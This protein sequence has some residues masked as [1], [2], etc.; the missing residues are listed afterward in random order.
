MPARKCGGSTL[1]PAQQVR[2][3][4]MHKSA[5]TRRTR[6]STENPKLTSIFMSQHILDHLFQRRPIITIPNIISPCPNLPTYPEITKPVRRRALIHL[7]HTRDGPTH[8]PAN[9][10]HMIRKNRNRRHFLSDSSCLF[11][12]SL[13]NNF[14]LT[15]TEFHRPRN[16]RRRIRR[17]QTDILPKSPAI[18]NISPQVP[19]QPR[20]VSSPRQHIPQ[21][22]LTHKT[23]LH[24]HS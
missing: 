17:T 9:N 1:I 19:L 10:M 4:P 6:E 23:N 22:S 7:H 3:I 5:L 2:R 12:Q 18:F 21:Q 15:L 24:S 13:P 16:Q 20:T 8:N 11:E 14:L